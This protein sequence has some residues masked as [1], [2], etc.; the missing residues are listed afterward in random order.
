MEWLSRSTSDQ[1]TSITQNSSKKLLQVKFIYLFTEET[2]WGIL[3]S[4]WEPTVEN[5]VFVLSYKTPSRMLF[6][7]FSKKYLC[8]IHV[9]S[10]FSSGTIFQMKWTLKA[11]L[12]QYFQIFHH[13]P[14]TKF[15]STLKA[16]ISII[17]KKNFDINYFVIRC[18]RYL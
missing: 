6:Q 4:S 1:Q 3:Q 9:N 10:C 17:S 7:K 2:L 5:F 8:L 12:L 11:L 14:I 13:I 18:S 16:F 15:T